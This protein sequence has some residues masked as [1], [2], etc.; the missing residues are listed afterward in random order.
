MIL[1]LLLL[2]ETSLSCTSKEEVLISG[3][4]PIVCKVSLEGFLPHPP[5]FSIFDIS[6]E[7]CN[8]HLNDER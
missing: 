3:K 8:I 4:V 5:T 6:Q 7:A 1:L 2:R